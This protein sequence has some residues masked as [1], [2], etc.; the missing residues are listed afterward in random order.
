MIYLSPSNYHHIHSPF[1]VEITER[2]HVPGEL[3][4]VKAFYANKVKGLFTL[5]ER[6][7][8]NGRWKEGFFSLGLVGAFNVGSIR[9]TNPADPVTT[10]LPHE[11]IYKNHKHKK[12]YTE[13]W[14]VQQGQRCGTF[15]VG[16]EKGVQGS[17]DPQS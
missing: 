3:L 7:V 6:V 14:L 17:W 13:P 5:N 10:N 1:D 8:L 9:I 12:G 16:L 4:P 11:L 15:E 2:V